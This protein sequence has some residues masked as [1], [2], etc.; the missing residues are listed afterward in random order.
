MTAITAGLFTLS[1]P[2]YTPP[3]SSPLLALP[4]MHPTP[5][6]PSPH[7]AIGDGP[8]A[9]ALSQSRG[10]SHGAS[11]MSMSRTASDELA[12]LLGL[13]SD[14][15]ELPTVRRDGSVATGT[16][17]TGYAS[18]PSPAAPNGHGY[19]PEPIGAHVRTSSDAAAAYARPPSSPHPFPTYANG[20]AHAAAAPVTSPHLSARA[21]PAPAPAAHAFPPHAPGVASADDPAQSVSFHLASLQSALAPLLAHA[22]ETNRLKR[23]LEF[24]HSEWARVD[25]QC[26]GLQVALASTEKNRVASPAPGPTFTAVLID[27]DGL[28]FTDELLQQGHAGGALAARNLLSALRTLIPSSP[29]SAISA[30]RTSPPPRLVYDNGVLAP[31]EGAVG[32]AVGTGVDVDAQPAE[33]GPVVVQVFLNKQGL[34]GILIK[35]GV[36]SGWATYD[37]FW[38]GF[39][40]AHN[41]FSVTDVGSG[42]EATDAK[43]REHL[44]LYALNRQCGSIIL[45]ASHDNGYANV[46][47]SLE[48][49]SRLSNVLLLKG[50]ATL[51]HELEQYSARVVSIPGLFRP[52]KL[53]DKAGKGASSARKTDAAAA[54]PSA[55]HKPDKARPSPVPAPKQPAPAP[56]LPPTFSAVVASPT[57]PSPVLAKKPLEV[58]NKPASA[59]AHHTRFSDSDTDSVPADPD[60]AHAFELTDADVGIASADE[61]S[62]DEWEA[63]PRKKR[64]HKLRP[65]PPPLTAQSST[66]G[67]IA[68]LAKMRQQLQHVRSVRALDPRPCHTFYL[69]PWG[70]KSRDGCEYAHDYDLD[71]A[72]LAELARL[73][74]EIMC[75]YAKG[76]RCQFKEADCVYGHRC[77]RAKQCTFGQTC[78]FRDI[79]GGHDE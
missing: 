60:P 61:D 30:F 79:P 16:G 25:R 41:L 65:A 3:P 51:A 57:P 26:R 42:K 14:D 71:D 53:F 47:S 21:A 27:G 77:P 55:N 63:A 15:W 33:T 59:P 8:G 37:A 32:G 34:G 50:Y 72:Q 54:A 7:G 68:P 73:A 45:G 58:N 52:S 20:H 78:R 23:E 66:A 10:P 56:P 64:A 5:A 17:F 2:S 62:D 13:K 74:K 9:G 4:P 46:L 76:N 43:I 40:G 36:I 49:E 44:R 69:S 75:P 22:E 70:C 48:T 28:L 29:T 39:S 19:V 38:Q 6:S 11:A 35:A 12:T 18:A 1:D 24:Y 31:E 67:Y